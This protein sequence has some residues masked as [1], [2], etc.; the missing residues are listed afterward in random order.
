MI[1]PNRGERKTKKWETF[2]LQKQ[3]QK[4]RARCVVKVRLRRFDTDPSGEQQRA[5]STPR[6][7]P[8]SVQKSFRRAIASSVLTCFQESEHSF[9][10]TKKRSR[11]VWTQ[12][13]RIVKRPCW[14]ITPR[15]KYYMLQ[16]AF[17]FLYL[18][19]GKEKQKKWGSTTPR[20]FELTLTPSS[21][22]CSATR[23]TPRGTA[24]KGSA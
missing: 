3:K 20:H 19:K 17:D 14:A 18:T 13:W 7:G 1:V 9:F 5:P 8:S 2:L 6:W 23:T 16:C 15:C 21:T 24:R 12:F 4:H 10:K 11:G 22:A